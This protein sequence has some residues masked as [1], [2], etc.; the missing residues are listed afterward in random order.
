MKYARKRHPAFCNSTIVNGYGLYF[1]ISFVI[2]FTTIATGWTIKSQYIT[3]QQ[4]LSNNLS[5]SQ[6]KST[7][8]SSRSAT[9]CMFQ[10][11]SLAKFL[12]ALYLNQVLEIDMNHRLFFHL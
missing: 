9:T 11:F 8:V 1:F 5:L 4:C 6:L 12:T 7:F 10:N 2:T 3:L